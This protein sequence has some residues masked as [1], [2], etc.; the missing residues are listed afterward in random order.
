MAAIT[1]AELP[2]IDDIRQAIPAG[3]CVVEYFQAGRAWIIFLLDQ[4]GLQGAGAVTTEVP[5]ETVIQQ[6]RDEIY[7][8]D[9][10]LVAGAML[11][12]AFLS[13]VLPTL[14]KVRDLI[15]VPHR[16]LHYVPF[17]ALWYEPAGDYAPPRQY[18]KNPFTLTTIP[19]ASYLPYLTRTAPP[20]REYGAAVVLGNPTGDLAG[21][22]LE[23]RQVAAK[24]GV[25]A[26]LG[27]SAT[28]EALL[29]AAA[30]AVLHVASH[31]S[32]NVQ[33][34]LLSGLALADG[35]V[36][37]EDLLNSGPAPGLL[38]LSGCVTGMSKTRPG[39]ELIGL[40]QAALR[41]GTRSVVAALWETFDESSAVFFGHFYDALID[42]IRVGEAI[43]WA[44]D[45]L[46]KG[47]GGYDHP[48]DWA[49]FL[50][51]GDPDQC[52]IERD[53]T[54]MAE[55]H[56]GLRLLDQGDVARREE[57]SFSMSPA[58]AARWAAAWAAFPI[59]AARDEGDSKDAQAAWQQAA[60]SADPEAAPLAM[61]S[62]REPRSKEDDADGAR[63]AYQQA[64][65]S[66]HP[67]AAPR[68]ALNLGALLFG[69]AD[70]EGARAAWQRAIDSGH[71]EVLPKAAINLGA[72]LTKQDD[73]E[74]ARASYQRAI[75]T[76]D[77]EL[78]PE[79]AFNL[80][81]LLGRNGDEEGARAAY[82]Q[83]IDSNHPDV[84]QRP[85]I[86]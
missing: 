40:A 73:T 65:D 45:A 72:L 57:P 7:N 28:R 31:G 34:P 77:D 67:E 79:A 68:A 44:R 38:V 6:F 27:P 24:L 59:D 62:S 12:Q 56:R 42:G 35:V 29:G 47:S 20:D 16:S 9:T 84:L 3:T 70:L 76:G 10:E 25:T 33:D 75:D 58:A 71:Y 36:T 49:P 32:Y 53:H 43:G 15:V 1:E 19:S 66:G 41:C 13:P 50:L 85:P 74:G 46:A 82:Q 4:D 2:T 51:F 21:A 37:V 69:Q 39:D 26:R 11:F 30:P 22:D 80:G 5:L 60:D 23:A 64:I 18:L 55:V 48:V 52:L 14:E 54:P 81:T 83:A 86:T 78:A 17:S 63:A 61:W 8:G